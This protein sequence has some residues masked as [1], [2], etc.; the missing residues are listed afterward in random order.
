MYRVLKIC[1]VLGL[2]EEMMLLKVAHLVSIDT[3]HAPLSFLVVKGSFFYGL[4]KNKKI[5]KIK[6]KLKKYKKNKKY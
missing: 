5:K 4:Q 3:V 6:N 2:L 1:L